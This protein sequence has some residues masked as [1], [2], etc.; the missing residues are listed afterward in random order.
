MKQLTYRVEGVDCPHCAAKIERSI[1]SLDGVKQARLDYLGGRLQVQ[2]EQSD[3]LCA[4]AQEAARQIEPSAVIKEPDGDKSQESEPDKPGARDAEPVSRTRRDILRIAAAGLLMAAGIAFQKLGVPA[5]ALTVLVLSAA[6]SGC[7][8]FT[9]ALRSVVFHPLRALRSGEF[10]D[11]NLLMSVAAIGA[12]CIGSWEEGAAVLF[13]YKLGEALESYAS[14]RSRRSVSSLLALR[15]DTANLVTPHGLRKID[16]RTVAVEQTIAILPGERTPLDCVILEGRTLVDT[17]ALTGEPVPRPAGPGDTLLAGYINKDGMVKARVRKAFGD[18]TVER[19]IELVRS[20][21]ANK[22]KAERFITRFARVYTPI[23]TGSALLLAVLPPLLFH[24]PFSGWVYRAL[25]FLVVSCPCALVISVPLGFFAGIGAASMNGVLVKGG[26]YLEALGRLEAV[27]FDKTGTLTRGVFELSKVIPAPDTGVS[28]QELLRL[29]ASAELRSHH[30]I[31]ASLRMAAGGM[32]LS[33]PSAVEEPAGLGIIAVVDGHRLA[34]GNEKLMRLEGAMTASS[35]EAADAGATVAHAARDGVY[36]GRLLI[37][38]AV[39]P[40]A[41]AAVSGLKELGVHRFAMLTGDASA[42]AR[43]VA[44]QAGIE[45][46]RAGLM[47]DGKLDAFRT[48]TAG[49]KGTSAFVGDGINDAPVLAGADIGIAMGGAGSD[50][51]VEAAD[52][53]VMNDSPSRVVTAVKIA[54]SVRRVVGA[55]IVFALIVKAV[56]LTLGALGLAGIWQALF[57]D[58][59]VML[60]AVLNSMRVLAGHRRFAPPETIPSNG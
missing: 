10:F 4:R 54:R 44:R 48:L 6:V 13:L 35:A 19:I 26:N 20:A 45:E 21:G 42:P 32:P 14:E 60:L 46:V 2:C 34:V 12:F 53:V 27:V 57:A 7:N 38:D 1:E 51:A 36:L 40:D 23:V 52:V 30:P 33:E 24:Q 55:N 16:P 49:L 15:P 5:A 11:E 3:G 56:V 17:S 31:A 37:A 47:P 28:A 18:S 25:V 39:R 59:G 41:A 9:N 50:A 8:V 58:T 29:A 43:A 22:A